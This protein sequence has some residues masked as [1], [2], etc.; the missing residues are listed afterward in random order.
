MVVVVGGEKPSMVLSFHYLRFSYI[1]KQVI[2]KARPRIPG[3]VPL[4]IE[5]RVL[6]CLFLIV[7]ALEIALQ[8]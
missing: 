6:G 1:E 8:I 3:K 2:A 4:H 5:Q 7:E